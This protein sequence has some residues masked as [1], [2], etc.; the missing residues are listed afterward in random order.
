MIDNGATLDGQEAV[1]HTLPVADQYQLMG[2]A[3]AAAIRGEAPLPYG[4]ED[5][6]QNMKILDALFASERS[7][8]WAEIA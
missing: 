2:E 4:L 3:F 6:R 5:A 1:I 7:G 8:G